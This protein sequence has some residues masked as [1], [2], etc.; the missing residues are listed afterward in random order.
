MMASDR[1]ASTRA[2]PAAKG[3]DPGASGMHP[4]LVSRHHHP[5]RRDLRHRHIRTYRAHWG[6]AKEPA[7]EIHAA[8][9]M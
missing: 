3:A 7:E 1:T 8:W 6:L 5:G 2:R 9:L 4:A